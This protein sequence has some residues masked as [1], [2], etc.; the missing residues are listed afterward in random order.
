MS[1]SDVW[2]TYCGDFDM[3]PDI[4]PKKKRI[5]AIGDLHG[6]ISILI[7]ILY[8]AKLFDKN[9]NW[10]AEPKDTI[11]IQVGDQLDSCRPTD[12]KCGYDGNNIANRKGDLA[13]FK[14]L[15][16]LGKKA[17][18]NGGKIINLIGNHELMNVEGDFRYVSKDDID[19]LKYLGINFDKLNLN[20][21]ELTSKHFYEI[22]KKLF[23]KGNLLSQFMACNRQT[24]VIIGSNLFVHAGIIPQLA[25][26]Y[27]IVNLNK[28]IRLWLLNKLSDTDHKVHIYNLLY[29]PD[30]SPF[31]T[32]IMGLIPKDKSIDN[33]YCE[34]IILP[35]LNLWNVDKLIVGHTPTFVSGNKMNSTCGNKLWRI[36]VGL[37]STFK[38]ENS[39]NAQYLEIIDDNIFNIFEIKGNK[40][41]KTN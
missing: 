12:F 3:I 25:K 41:Y 20:K 13:I 26:K 34:K 4:L 37:S 19:Y 38:K 18:K 1:N 30:Y 23:E 15:Y 6:D 16:N 14:L 21:N 11:L 22:R 33:E 40:C 17:E 29:N 9:F 5:V 24:A 7:K 10:I 27:N 28:I 36:D 32:R 2:K 8:C 39:Y 31:W 35:S